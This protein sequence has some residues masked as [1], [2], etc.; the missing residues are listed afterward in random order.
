MRKLSSTIAFFGAFSILACSAADEPTES[1]E[2]TGESSEALTG[3]CNYNTIGHPCDPDGSTGLLLECGGVCHPTPTA[4]FPY[5]V[6]CVAIT[7]VG[8]PT[9]NGRVC[10]SSGGTSCANTCLN[11]ACVA[12]QAK[13]GA[14]CRPSSGGGVFPD[15]CDGACNANGACTSLANPV[16]Y[17][18]EGCVFNACDMTAASTPAKINLPKGATCTDSNQCTLADVCDGAGKCTAG[19]T[20]S[21]DDGNVCTTDT[22]NPNNGACLGQVNTNPCDD[23]DACTTGDTCGGGTCQPGKPVVCAD[24]NACTTDSCD[25]AT[26]CKYVAKDCNDNNACTADGCDATTGACAH[27]PI[28]C[29]DNNP[30]T[31][32]SCATAT[33]CVLSLI[34]ISEPTRPY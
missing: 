18:R 9:L 14:A 17:G 23:K 3:G 16:P 29:N 2:P 24:N 12:I 1:G 26:G 19:S 15:S 5:S 34:H 25:K 32:D 22:C 20:K 10:G 6:T 31:T 27:K 21:C 33:G 30:C 28:A 7:T 4:T 13:T 8:I 11:G